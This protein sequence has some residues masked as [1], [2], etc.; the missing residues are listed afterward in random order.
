[1]SAE[2]HIFFIISHGF[3]SGTFV[4]WT[5]GSPRL[6]T[7]EWC[8]PGS[9]SRQGIPGKTIGKTSRWWTIR[10][11]GDELWY[12][13]KHS[14]TIIR[15][16]LTLENDLLYVIQLDLISWSNVN[17]K[18]FSQ[19]SNLYS[20]AVCLK[21]ALIW[22]RTNNKQPLLWVTVFSRATWEKS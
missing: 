10:Q 9:T 15:S 22:N 1:M 2:Q 14:K 18:S 12:C 5:A 21:K 13:N 11:V 4:S 17:I 20:G 3:Y 6:G 7:S 16:S 8:L 19:N